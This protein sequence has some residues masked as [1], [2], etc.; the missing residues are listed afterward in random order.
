MEPAN[1]RRERTDPFHFGSCVYIYGM[2]DAAIELHGSLKGRNVSVMER[3]RTLV[4]RRILIK[5]YDRNLK[6]ASL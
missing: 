1:R 5:V 3:Y 6:V 4:V 2:F